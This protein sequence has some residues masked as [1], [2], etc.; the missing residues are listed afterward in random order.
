[1]CYPKNKAGEYVIPD[2]V[3]D[4]KLTAGFEKNKKLT[5]LILN[6]KVTE[7]DV[8]KLEGCSA[9]E[10]IV[11]GASVKEVK[12]NFTKEYS[13]E[14]DSLKEISVSEK[15]DC[16]ASYG[17]AL[18][19]KDFTKLYFIPDA[20]DKLE[21]NE[22]VEEIDERIGLDKNNYNE[23][24]LPDTNKNFVVKNNV[25]YDKGM[26]RIFIFPSVITSYKLPATVNDVSTIT[27][28]MYIDDGD[29]G[30]DRLSTQNSFKELEAEKQQ[31]NMGKIGGDCL[32]QMIDY[33]YAN[34]DEFRL[35]L[36][37]S[38]GTQ[39]ENMVHEMSEVEVQATHDFVEVMRE[40][41]IEVRE[42]DPKLEH[43]LVSGM[44]TAFFELLIHK[45]DIGE[46][47][48]YLE[49]LREFYTAGW[50][51]LFDMCDIQKKDV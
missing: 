43:V 44:F 6:D 22:N 23:I 17:G 14:L 49:Q 39:Y 46:A 33:M 21:L 36:M 11:L 15:N 38:K 25:L 5:A 40:N 37:C 31:A 34:E 42:I 19:S 16:Y 12:M 29:N 27:S 4:I 3:T 7:F 30:Y 24:I 32:E 13:L 50:M 48:T 18:Y 10:K 9:L 20:M 1:M 45:N 35:I 51:R 41:G 28:S 8:R 2:T 26:T 47:K